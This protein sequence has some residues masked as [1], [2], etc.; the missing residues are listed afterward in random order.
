[1]KHYTMKPKNDLNPLLPAGFFGWVCGRE[2]RVEQ[3]RFCGVI[4][5]PQLW[6]KTCR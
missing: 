6:Q 3:R 4:G 1:M 2:R 5:S